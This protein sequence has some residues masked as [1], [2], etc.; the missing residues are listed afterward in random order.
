MSVSSIWT[1]L[2]YSNAWNRENADGPPKKLYKLLSNTS[3]SILW[4][5]YICVYLS[6]PINHQWLP[7]SSAGDCL[8]KLRT[9]GPE[10]LHGCSSNPI[11][12]A[13]PQHNGDWLVQALPYLL[14]GGPNDGATHP[15][16]IPDV[17]GKHHWA[18][19]WAILRLPLKILQGFV[20]AAKIS[21]LSQLKP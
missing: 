9:D 3:V 13:G 16:L 19:L 17:P 4:P 5:R 12:G 11:G 1:S 21:L 20:V 10:M 18:V 15:P 8:G 2:R 14:H 6:L 7:P